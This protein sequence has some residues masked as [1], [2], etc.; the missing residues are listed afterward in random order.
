MVN[1]LEDSFPLL[2]GGG[3]RITSP[4][5]KKYNCIAHAAGDP[6]RWWWPVPPEVEE[7]FW[8]AGVSQEES[9]PAFRDAFA[10]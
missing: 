7:V 3:Y 10:P 1:P 2:A 6:E 9:L 5:D 4:S 8:P